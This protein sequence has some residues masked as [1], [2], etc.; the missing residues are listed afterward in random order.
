MDIDLKYWIWFSSLVKISPRRRLKLLEYFGDPAFLWECPEVELKKLPICTPLVIEAI[1]D[2][3]CRS[4]V[5][6]IIEAIK[7]CNGTIITIRDGIYPE[8]LRNIPGAPAVLY[9]RGKLV[10]DEICI[11][12]VGSRRA[13]SYGLD[14]AKRLS[15][16]LAGRGV[17]IISGMARGIDS[18]AHTGALEAGGRT[19]AVLG[20]G[21]D[22]IYPYENSG[23]M[24]RICQS[25]AVLSEYIPGTPPISFNFPAR[26]R[27][28]SGLSQGVTIIEASDRSGS[29]ITA[30]FALEQGREVFAVPGNINSMNS[31]GTN[32]LIRDGAKLVTNA[33]DILEELKMNNTANDN[34]YWKKQLLQNAMGEEELTISQR[35]LDGPAHI[36][37]I[38]RDCGIS[39][40]L[41]G[42]VLVMLE[43]SGFVEQ[44]PGKF[45]KLAE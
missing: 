14:M 43:L 41:A 29:L 6:G 34:V 37:V 44:L 39:V 40:Q 24:D 20:C 7:K 4:D 31:S 1:L 32:R 9:C 27:I 23:L 16:D 42:S 35:L 33:G 28:I 30:E 36:D 19:V 13:T 5:P 2:K 3:Q 45:Y 18:K 8:A 15:R 26:N 17:T 25:G 11:A 38:S 22:V 21:V 10:K 12:V